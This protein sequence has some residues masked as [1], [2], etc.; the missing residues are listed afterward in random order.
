MNEIE[1]TRYSEYQVKLKLL[2]VVL[3]ETIITIYNSVH[4]IIKHQKIYLI[5]LSI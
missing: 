3:S 1:Y 4:L 2:S 5:Q